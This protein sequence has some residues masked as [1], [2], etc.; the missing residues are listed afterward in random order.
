MLALRLRRIGAAKQGND[1]HQC[2]TNRAGKSSFEPLLNEHNRTTTWMDSCRVSVDGTGAITATLHTTSAGQGHETL[3]AVAIGEVLEIDPDR[4]RVVRPASLSALPNNSPVGSRMAIIVGSAA[5]NAARK[6]RGQLLAIA[7]HDFRVAE[8][9]L[10]YN[11]G[12]TLAPD[13][14][15][16]TWGDLVNIAHREYFRMSPGSE[17]GLA[18]SAIYQ[19]PGGGQLPKDG[20]VQMSPCHSA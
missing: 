2:R 1:K 5:V 12:Q 16:L 7:A 20:P 19:V 8:E 14:R 10:R 9:S 18:A 6:L 17:P 11:A 15:A 13:G 4:I 3:V